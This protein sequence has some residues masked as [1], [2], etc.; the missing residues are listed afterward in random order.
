MAT[1]WIEHDPLSLKYS[2]V[3]NDPCVYCVQIDGITVYVGSTRQFRTRFCEHKFRNGYENNIHLPWC[4]IANTH[5]LTVKVGFTKRYGDWVMRELR[6]IR[7][8]KPDFNIA[9]KSPRIQK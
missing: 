2:G 6:L 4:S 3:R 8:L 5:K 9:H 7:R 1:N